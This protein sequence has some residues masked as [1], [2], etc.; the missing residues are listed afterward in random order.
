M[1]QFQKLSLY[2]EYVI[3]KRFYLY[4]LRFIPLESKIN[5][6]NYIYRNDLVR[7]KGV[8]VYKALGVIT[9]PVVEPY[10]I[11]TFEQY[12]EKHLKL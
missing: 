9:Q 4:D 11:L 2:I 7:Q 12:C 10:S 5:P 1:D 6:P 3:E 8:K